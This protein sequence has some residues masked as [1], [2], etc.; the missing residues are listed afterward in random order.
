MTQVTQNT[1]YKTDSTRS[2]VW[3]SRLNTHV[4]RIWR[5]FPVIRK[6]LE[7]VDEEGNRVPDAFEKAQEEVLVPPL[8]RCVHS[9]NEDGRTNVTW[10]GIHPSYFYTVDADGIVSCREFPDEHLDLSHYDTMLGVA[11]TIFCDLTS[12]DQQSDAVNMA[13]LACEH[14]P[15]WKGEQLFPSVS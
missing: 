4:C 12:N 10:Y 13:V 6:G 9:D 3:A 15:E 5:I 7:M 2:F 14:E 8:P 1:R 11:A